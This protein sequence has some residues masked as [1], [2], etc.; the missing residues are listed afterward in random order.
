MAKPDNA[1]TDAEWEAKFSGPR[2]RL[3]KKIFGEIDPAKIAEAEKEASEIEHV[4]TVQEMRANREK[5]SGIPTDPWV[6]QY[7]VQR[8]VNNGRIVTYVDDKKLKD[9]CKEVPAPVK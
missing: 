5:M 9:E 2:D 3:F 6:G 7:N 8:R 1:M 4:T